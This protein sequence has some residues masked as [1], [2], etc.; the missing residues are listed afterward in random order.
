MSVHEATLWCVKLEAT[1]SYNY[2][3]LFCK[4]LLVGP[5]MGDTSSLA[6]SRRRLTP[7]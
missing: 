6:S 2:S 4:A 1:T 7:R 5:K 3:S